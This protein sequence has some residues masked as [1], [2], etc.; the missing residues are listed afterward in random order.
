MALLHKLGY[1]LASAQFMLIKPG[2]SIRFRRLFVRLYQLHC[3]VVILFVGVMGATNA[4][5]AQCTLPIPSSEHIVS[6]SP[7]RLL[8]TSSRLSSGY[9]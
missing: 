3:F 7:A 6:T 1:R 2:M 8:D 5:F 9:R 4:S